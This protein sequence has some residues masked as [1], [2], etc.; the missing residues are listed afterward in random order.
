[1]AMKTSAE[2]GSD[3]ENLLAEGPSVTGKED[4]AG[5][6]VK[7]QSSLIKVGA[8][9]QATGGSSREDGLLKI[10]TALFYAI[11][12]FLIMVVNKQVLTVHGFPS[13]Q[14]KPK[15]KSEHIKGCLE[16]LR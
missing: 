12:S 8:A 5:S 1:M 3:A 9:R 4:A 7:V 6:L 10:S 14:V 16:P 2:D 13:F 15:R 11:S